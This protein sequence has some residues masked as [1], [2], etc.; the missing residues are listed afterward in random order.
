MKIDPV[1]DSYGETHGNECAFE[2]AACEA[3]KKK[4]RLTIVKD[5]HLGQQLQ[6]SVPLF[7]NEKT[8]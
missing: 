8:R 1:C 7:A 6:C 4:K 3:K 5:I 2:I